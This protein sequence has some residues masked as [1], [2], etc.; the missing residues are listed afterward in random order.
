MTF[1]RNNVLLRVVILLACV[2]AISITLT[3][4][5]P[6]YHVISLWGV[7]IVAVLV[8]KIDLVHPYF[9]F[10]AFFVLYSSAYTIIL[11]DGYQTST[12]Y[13]SENTIM[14]IIALFTALM[15]IGP[16]SL[17]LKI[18]NKQKDNLDI[19][20]LKNDDKILKGIL[21]LLFAVLLICVMLVSRL[22]IANKSELVNNQYFSF[23]IATY[24]T[25][26]A[27]LFSGMYIVN[28][29]KDTRLNSI[30]YL[31]GFAIVFFSLFTAERDAIFR[32]LLVIICALFT[33]DRI[34]RKKI[35]LVLALGV[36]I[37]LLMTYFKYFFVRGEV[38]DSYQEQSLI[39]NFLSSDFT[40]AGENMQV[41]LNNPWTKSVSNLSLMI[42][43]IISPFVLG[44]E[45]FNIGTWFNDTFYFGSYSRAFTLLGQGYVMGGAFGVVIL[46]GVV[47]FFVRY[48]YKK[49]SK[50]IYWLSAYLFLIPTVVSSFRGSLNTIFVT[51]FRIAGFGL[52]SY[53]VIRS[54]IIELE[55]NKG[56]KNKQ[57]TK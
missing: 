53:L 23:R 3:T 31:L 13:T 25:R 29:H 43:D 17:D 22:D 50:N 21:F 16:E 19:S 52:F 36:I 27:T 49:A 24:A 9:W 20:K 38:R 48:L 51:M 41:L 6:I 18:V 54:I 1:S 40:A 42:T 7:V 37:I 28:T 39:M 15:V 32:Y 46:F 10:S 56:K 5:N 34:N 8:T 12:G 26:F 55:M 33:T 4:S 2:I 30:V 11:I 14:A 47:G 45:T 57:E 35:P 44:L